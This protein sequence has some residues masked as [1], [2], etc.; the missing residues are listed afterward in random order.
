VASVGVTAL[1]VCAAAYHIQASAIYIQDAEDIISIIAD[2]AKG[3]ASCSR[4]HPVPLLHG[5]PSYSLHCFNGTH[6]LLTL[7][8]AILSPLRYLD[9]KLFT[10]VK[11]VT[12]LIFRVILSHFLTHSCT[13]VA[14]FSAAWCVHYYYYISIIIFYTH[15]SKDPS[16]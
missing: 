6:C 4:H 1:V 7:R 9:S 3:P 11:L 5:A 16:G 10:I 2:Q 12:I 8:A 15:G 14:P 13:S